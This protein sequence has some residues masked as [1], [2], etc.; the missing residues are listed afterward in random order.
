MAIRTTTRTVTFT[1]PFVLSSADGIQVPGSYAVDTDEELLESLSFPVWR[2]VGT[3]IRLTSRQ[4]G[5][6][7]FE[8][9]PIDPA[10]L[11]TVLAGDTARS[12][13]Q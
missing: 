6:T 8:T 2:R 10:E 9:V 12:H 5:T 4:G 3:W 11:D 1:R 13:P 7:V